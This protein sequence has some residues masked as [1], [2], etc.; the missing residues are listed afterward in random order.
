MVSWWTSV[1]AEVLLR[2]SGGLFQLGQRG[3]DQD[4]PDGRYPPPIGPYSL[5]LLK[6]VRNDDSE[7]WVQSGNL[8]LYCNKRSGPQRLLCA[9]FLFQ[10][11]ALEAQ[12]RPVSVW[13]AVFSAAA[14]IQN[15]TTV[16]LA[17]AALYQ[18]ALLFLEAGERWKKKKKGGCNIPSSLQPY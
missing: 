18:E 16:R 7:A 4:A 14:R 8:G 10:V 15:G 17:A 3:L 2:T 1:S 5:F 6:K 12:N 13:A 9:N 11:G